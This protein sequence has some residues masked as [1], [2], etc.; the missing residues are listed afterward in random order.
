MK[1]ENPVALRFILQDEIYLLNDDK[2]AYSLNA[3]QPAIQQ[4]VVEEIVPVADPVSHSPATET[5]PVNFNYLGG[6]K[7]KLSGD[8]ALP[9]A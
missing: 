3:A 7:K 2:A 1:V 6:H 5:Q 9:A 4:P 8:N